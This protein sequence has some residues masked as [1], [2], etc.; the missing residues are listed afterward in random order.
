MIADTDVLVVGGGVMG[1]ALA[2]YLAREG[3]EV[4]VID[5]HDLN[6]Q[7]SGTNAGSLHVQILSHWARVEDAATI[8]AT[9]RPLPLYVEA[10]EV[11]RA[12]SRE[13]DCDI[14]F[15]AKGGFMVAETA[16]EMRLLERKS[17]RERECGVDSRVVSGGELRAFAPYF[18][19]AVIGASFCPYEGKVNP[20]LATP[21]LARGAER[22]GARFLRHTEL[23][24]LA[25]S[26]AEFEAAT[27]RGTIRARRVVI[28]AGAWAGEIAAMIGLELPMSRRALHMN[29]TEPTAPL[30]PHLVQHMGQR[31]TLK[32]ASNGAMIVGGGWPA[33]AD[34]SATNPEVL[35]TS[36]EGNL[37]IAARLVPA[38]AELRLVRT[39]TGIINVMID[40][41]PVL[42]PVPAVPGLFVAMASVGYT[43][44]PICAR[45][46]AAA[47][48]GEDPPMDIAPFSITRLEA[49]VAAAAASTF[50]EHAPSI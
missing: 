18:S 46:V 11:W 39:W 13:L 16:E 5:R 4:T 6:T 43:S 14:E 19:D 36:I 22:A 33:G 29:V 42:G 48:R 30:V 10:V 27:S 28:A 17:L 35:R 34:L 15:S 12:L 40:G 44:G 20:I 41:S 32:Q 3:V 50:L 26:R 23:R 21:A 9:Q 45:L 1:C 38:L 31:L 49:G 47:I 7:A 24:A 37:W 25:R 8:A 2:Y